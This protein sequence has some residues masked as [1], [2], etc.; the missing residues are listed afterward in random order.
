[1]RS[2]RNEH[3]HLPMICVLAISLL[4]LSMFLML[5]CGGAGYNYYTDMEYSSSREYTMI[6]GSEDFAEDVVEYNTEEYDAIIENDF[7]LTSDEP[8]STFS[9][10]VDT[11]SYSN[12]RR[13]L[14]NGS[15][16]PAGAVRIEE[17]INYF[18]YAYQPPEDDV[19]FASRVEI[20]TC[21]W[22]PDHQLARIALKG[23]VVEEEERPRANLVFLI[24]ASGSMRDANKLPLVK[25]GLKMLVRQLGEDDFVTIVAYAGESGILLPPTSCA[26]ARR[27]T[28]AIDDIGAGGSTAGAAGI[29][30]A[31]EAAQSNFNSNGIN[32]I[33][34]CTDGDFNV[35]ISDESSLVKLITEKAQS[36]VFLSVFG[37]GMGNL[38]DA[39]L[40][41]LADNGNGNYG[42]IDTRNEA[43]K[44]FVE[45]LM[46]TLITIA[47]DV[48]IQIDFNP[49]HVQAYRLIGYEN[50]LLANRDFNDD[51]KD[52]GEI[53]AGHTVTAFYEL[54]PPGV[55][56]PMPA[57]ETSRYQV[58]GEL[59]EAAQGDEIFTVKIRYKEPDGDT[60]RLLT[61]PAMGGSHPG[62][63]SGDFQF[64]TAVALFGQLLRDG[65]YTNDAT[66][67]T[68]LELAEGSVGA[69]PH[70]YRSEFLGLVEE[71][72]SL[73]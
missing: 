44:V 15:L 30:D 6:P 16:P 29:R 62:V 27:I 64:A 28:N 31:Y 50:R 18:D 60:S 47:K 56:V 32:R 3:R 35:G 66:Y 73:D 54:V 23:R 8:L 12:I 36:G 45:Q 14:N 19:P 67:E 57:I 63:P 43:K 17:M 7:L 58:S 20:A 69:D 59:T 21:P 34:L 42:Y 52:A 11:A 48:K 53:G 5:G 26:D 65:S 55:D 41:S 38:K 61:F 24:D 9:I 22:A 25:Q 71:A 37:F 46:G 68:V 4:T 72:Q 40:E 33:I 39:R 2:I 10:D 49:T 1:M 70:G 51:E 13:Y